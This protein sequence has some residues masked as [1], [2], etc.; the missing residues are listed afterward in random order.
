MQW[1]NGR[2]LRCSGRVP[3]CSGS[4]SR[5]PRC[6]G[7]RSALAA[8]VLERWGAMVD[9][10]HDG[11]WVETRGAMA[12]M[13]E[14]C[15]AVVEWTGLNETLPLPHRTQWDSSSAPQDSYSAPLALD[16]MGLFLYPSGSM[17]LFL[18]TIELFLCTTKLFRCPT[19]LN[20][21]LPLPHQTQWDTPSAPQDSMDSSSAHWTQWDSSSAPPD[22]MG[23]F[24]CP[25]DSMGLLLCTTGLFLC[26]PDSMGL[27]L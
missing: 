21:T 23:L 8:M 10:H 11:A 15:G 12:A 7:T 20:E 25:L 5:A 16:S 2:A 26:P 17:G 6:T 27:F 3:Q 24:L 9:R 13:V 14:P 19:G 1:Y 22:S 4:N 18:G